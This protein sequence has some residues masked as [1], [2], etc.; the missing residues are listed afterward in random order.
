MDSYHH[1][2]SRSR[3]NDLIIGPK[4]SHY[5]DKST[6]TTCPQINFSHWNHLESNHLSSP[7]VKSSAPIIIIAPQH[8]SVPLKLVSAHLLNKCNNF[9]CC[10][11]SRAI[12]DDLLP[13]PPAAFLRQ[14]PRS[15]E[16]RNL[17]SSA[18]FSY[19][20]RRRE[21]SCNAEK[22]I[23]MSCWLSMNTASPRRQPI[24]SSEKRGQSKECTLFALINSLKY[25]SA[26]SI[27]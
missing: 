6:R 8:Y 14:V 20:S 26:D 11:R 10:P 1:R 5:C 2:S 25:I 24:R 7:F 13:P 21:G 12:S 9:H 17:L 16:T 18:C 19:R 3:A 23:E 22:S 27:V 15:S 4:M